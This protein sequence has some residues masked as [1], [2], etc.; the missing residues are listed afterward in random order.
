MIAIFL[1]NTCN[2]A[3]RSYKSNEIIIQYPSD[4]HADRCILGY[5]DSVKTFIQF[6]NNYQKASCR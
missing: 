1:H 4:D 3:D 2:F 6:Q 5:R